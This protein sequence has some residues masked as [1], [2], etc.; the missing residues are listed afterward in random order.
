LCHGCRTYSYTNNNYGLMNRNNN[1]VA[2]RRSA[3]WIGAEPCF[4]RTVE[5]FRI[6]PHPRT[7]PCISLRT[8]RAG[9]SCATLCRFASLCF[10]LLCF[11]VGLFPAPCHAM[12]CHAMPRALCCIALHGV[13][14][15]LPHSRAYKRWTSSSNP[16][17]S[18]RTKSPPPE[19]SRRRLHLPRSRS[20][21]KPIEASS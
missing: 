16:S 20:S 6:D 3:V 2:F 18:R 13:R 19:C 7:D 11:A 17:L 21:R 5:R 4:G 9:A 12:P 14:Q 8:I 10:V 15:Y 1:N